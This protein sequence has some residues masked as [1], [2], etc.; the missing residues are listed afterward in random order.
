MA[1]NEAGGVLSKFLLLSFLKKTFG[2][3]WFF[4]LKIGGVFEKFSF[5]FSY[6][7]TF[8]ENIFNEL[9]TGGG[10]ASSSKTLT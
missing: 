4:F 7:K 3:R 9:K 1:K 6:K 8:D 10:R 2:K 5:T